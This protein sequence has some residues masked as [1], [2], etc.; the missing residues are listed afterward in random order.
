MG[1]LL[2]DIKDA[3]RE[4]H[5]E[6]HCHPSPTLGHWRWVSPGPSSPWPGQ[7]KGPG[8][9]HS[10]LVDASRWIEWDLSRLTL[11]LLRALQRAKSLQTGEVSPCTSRP[12]RQACRGE[13]R[14]GRVSCVSPSVCT[15]TD[16]LKEEP[17][18]GVWLAATTTLKTSVLFSPQRNVF[19]EPKCLTRKGD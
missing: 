5:G 18:S 17:S 15:C 13:R 6:A 19:W 10:Q 8:L 3:Q 2:I 9:F 16:S 14:P 11:E 12:Q 7:L 1:V 4:G